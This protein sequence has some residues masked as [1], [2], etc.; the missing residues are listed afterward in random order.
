MSR[1][2]LDTVFA[3]LRRAW[4]LRWC[5]GRAMLWLMVLLLSTGCR[6]TLPGKPEIAAP[7]TP[8]STPYTTMALRC[9]GRLIDCYYGRD[10]FRLTV[11]V[12]PILDE[13]RGPGNGRD[14]VPAQATHMVLT[15]LN[16]IHQGLQVSAVWLTSGGLEI[17]GAVRP[18]MTISAAITI[19]DRGTHLRGKKFDIG[20]VGISPVVEE[21]EAS[22]QAHRATSTLSLDMMVFDFPSQVARPLAHAQLQVVLQRVSQQAEVGVAMAVVG[23]GASVIEKKVEGVGA[24]L[25]RLVELAVLQTIARRYRLPYGRCLDTPIEDTLLEQRILDY[26]SAKSARDQAALIR[27]LLREYGAP[28]APQGPWDA[29]VETRLEQLKRQYNLQWRQGDRGEVYRALYLNM[30]LTPPQR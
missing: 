7:P 12:R 6:A 4:L 22:L 30:P 5:D 24:A 13:T 27:E 23:L 11:A 25:R 15:T 19:Y 21:L 17:R 8:I 16:T 2:L 26:F 20:V 3:V 28:V 18:D 1:T 9:L 14:E 10:Q 29:T